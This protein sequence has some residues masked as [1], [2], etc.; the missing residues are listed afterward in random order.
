MPSSTDSAGPGGNYS[1]F[2]N[3]EVDALTQQL[4]ETI[5]PEERLAIMDE[6]QALLMEHLP[7]AF[8]YNAVLPY[9]V[10]DVI[11]DWVIYPS[12]DWFFNTVYK[13][14]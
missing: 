10:R 6:I 1:Y 12:G 11:Q 3:A 2:S 5:D 8:L 7:A 4:A 9:V 13:E 14:Q